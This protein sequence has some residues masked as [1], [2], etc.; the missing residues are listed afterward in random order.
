M[1]HGKSDWGDS[2]TSDHER[3][4][5]PR[6][7][8]A[9]ARMGRFLTEAGLEPTAI[10]SS[11]AERAAATARLASQSGDW[12][13]TI[14]YDSRLYGGGCKTVFETVRLLGADVQCALIVGHN[15]TWAETTSSLVGGYALRFPT[16]AIACLDIHTPWN[17]VRP[18]SAELRWFVS[19]RLLEST[20]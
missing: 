11:T 18:T 15:P 14:V 9:A 8:R 13:S 20:R 3:P 2:W 10:I 12:Q 16:A 6:G 5:A 17:G 1:R 19:P 7:E 4:L